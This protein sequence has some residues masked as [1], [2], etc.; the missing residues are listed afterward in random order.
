M[1]RHEL[2]PNEAMHGR[3]AAL[4]DEAVKLH[5]LKRHD[6]SLG[7]FNAAIDAE[8]GLAVA[9]YGKGFEMSC[10]G[11]HGEAIPCFEEALKIDPDLAEAHYEKGC[12]LSR[13]GRYGRGRGVPWK[14]DEAEAGSCHGRI[15]RKGFALSRLKR[16]G[17]AVWCLDAAISLKPDDAVSHVAKGNRAEIPEKSTT[18]PCCAL[19]RRQG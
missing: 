19:T 14:G 8:P 4:M 13:L 2:E 5:R 16:H 11:R 9:H 18:R 7:C 15:T 6:E 1:S 3:A 12:S 10:L 17:E